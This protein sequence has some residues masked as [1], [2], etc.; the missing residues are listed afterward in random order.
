M[1]IL[2]LAAVLLL[3]CFALLVQLAGIVKRNSA[4][5]MVIACFFPL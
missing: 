5:I 1:L 3:D 4:Y 2:L